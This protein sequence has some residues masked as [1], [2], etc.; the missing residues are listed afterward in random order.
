[1]KP[2]D[3]EHRALSVDPGRSVVLTAGA[4]SGKTSVLQLRLLN[5]LCRVDRPEHVLAIT[6]TNKAVNEIV[7][8][9]LAALEAAET[10]SMPQNEHEAEVWR[11]ARK[12]LERDRILGWNIRTNPSRLRIMTFDTFC[13]SLSRRLPMMSGFGGGQVDENPQ[14]LYE[15]AVIETFSEI[16][17]LDAPGELRGALERILGAANNRIDVLIPVFSSL[18]SKRDQWAEQVLCLDV[19]ANE[20]VIKSLVEAEYA[21][22]LKKFHSVVSDDVLRCLHDASVSHKKLSWASDLPAAG[23]FTLDHVCMM[24]AL[25]DVFLT[26]DGK[27]KSKVDARHGFVA[28][29]QPTKFFNEFLETMK[30]DLEAR[31]AL[32]DACIRLRGMPDLL[33]NDVIRER[34]QDVSV[35]LRY[36]LASLKLVFDRTGKVDF[37]EVALRAI[38]ALG[39]GDDDI[40]EALLEE[41]RVLHVMVDEMQ[42]TSVSQLR[43]LER[44]CSEWGD[45]N[46]RSIFFCGDPIQSIYL[47]RGATPLRFTDLIENPFF[48]GRRLEPLKL[49]VNFR[50]SKEIVSWVNSAMNKIVSNESVP[51]ISSMHYNDADTFCPDMGDVKVV[52]IVGGDGQTEADVVIDELKTLLKDNPNQSVAI[53]VRSRGH[54]REIIPLL[55]S[56]GI[57]F[58]GQDIDCIRGSLPVA[59]IIG[60]I[61]AML[62]DG[63]R[64]NWTVLLRSSFVGLSWADVTTLCQSKDSLRESLFDESTRAELSADGQQRV[65]RLIE[66]L[67]CLERDARSKDLLWL[68]RS[69]WFSLGGPAVVD[70]AQH[71]DIEKVFNLFANHISQGCLIEERG[72]ESDLDKLYATP[73]GGGVNLMTIHKAKGLEFDSVLLMGVGRVGANADPALFNWLSLSDDFCLAPKPPKGE[74]ATSP[75]SRLY[76]FLG[77]LNKKELHDEAQRLLYVGVTR[78]KRHLRIFAAAEKTAVGPFPAAR[79]MLVHL[80]PHV[81]EEF[82]DAEPLESVSEGAVCLHTPK[83]LVID[84]NFRVD[85]PLPLQVDKSGFTLPA[86][87]LLSSASQNGITNAE[88]ERVEGI[89]FHRLLERIG[90]DGLSKWQDEAILTKKAALASALRRLGYPEAS[91]SKGVNNLVDLAMKTLSSQNGRWIL[92]CREGGC[93][94]PLS[95]ISDSISRRFILDRIFLDKDTLWIVDYKTASCG[96]GENYKA[97]LERERNTYL[98]KMQAYL[99]AVMDTGISQKAKAALYFPAHDELLEVA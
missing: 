52:P 21:S 27:V 18:I 43:L 45:S 64:L 84:P 20:M 37:T 91:I 24:P 14:L 72:F 67:T 40:G 59:D 46:D 88:N 7:E 13:A 57:P 26:K 9:V 70:S 15:Q 85:L 5:C 22:A 49:T 77:R 39:V 30:V 36:V 55:K 4:G 76:N 33:L 68:C 42:D 74:D 29:A 73:S 79:S 50:S 51:G 53:L 3:F 34:C 78:A 95:T 16:E 31:T 35:V 87:S 25:A 10:A 28:K 94:V 63:D 83:S 12:V 96:E 92:A 47:F 11:S 62:H 38:A 32:Q 61:K 48:A 99:G 23:C 66:A 93:E 56:E 90:K 8:R 86:E 17:N 6:F 2:A 41:D 58:S 97:F 82:V 80:W 65:A 60:L 1:M 98:D 71:A 19:D 54:L 89:V 44:L 69:L 81:Q 75:S